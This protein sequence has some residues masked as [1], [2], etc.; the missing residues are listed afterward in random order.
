MC[1]VKLIGLVI[2]ITNSI[3]MLGI[4]LLTLLS[5]WTL[6]LLIMQELHNPDINYFRVVVGSFLDVIMLVIARYIINQENPSKK[7]VKE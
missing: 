4:L 7:K 2:G 3:F 5:T 6:F 1:C